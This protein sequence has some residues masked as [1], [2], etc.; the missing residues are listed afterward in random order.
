MGKSGTY[1]YVI[2][3]MLF[4]NYNI[5]NVL[6]ISGNRE[7]ELFE[8]VK[9]DKKKYT[10]WFLNQKSIR[11]SCSKEKIELM[12]KVINSRIKIMWGGDLK[13]VDSIS[14]NTLIVWD[15]SHF[16]QSR[17]NKPFEFFEKNGLSSILDGSEENNQRN[18]SLLTVSATPFSELVLNDDKTS[19]KTCLLYTSPSPRD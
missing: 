14:D 18:I 1:W 5:K 6:I 19:C 12:R 9:E 7:K 4:G 17:E 8:Q 3:K 11:D 13:R 10:E 16:A 2:L 15:E